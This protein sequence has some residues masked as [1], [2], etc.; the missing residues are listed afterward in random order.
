MLDAFSPVVKKEPSKFTIEGDE[1]DQT[2]WCLKAGQKG[3]PQS[4]TL[5]NSTGS[6]MRCAQARRNSG[7]WSKPCR[8]LYGLPALPSRRSR[9]CCRDVA[10]SNQQRRALEE[11]GL[12]VPVGNWVLESACNQ[13]ARWV[14]QGLTNGSMAVNISAHQFRQADFCDRISSTRFVN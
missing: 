5:Q 3:Q 14:S 10:A 4:T 6:R 7:R 8:K 9:P 2:S 11:C 12:I 13:H 1:N